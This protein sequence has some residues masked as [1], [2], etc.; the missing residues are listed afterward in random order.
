MR[1]TAGICVLLP[2]HS[3]ERRGAEVLVYLRLLEMFSF[4]RNEILYNIRMCLCGSLG[5][6]CSLLRFSW[7]FSELKT[8]LKIHF[9]LQYNIIED[10]SLQCL[11][12]LKTLPGLCKIHKNCLFF[13][14]LEWIWIE[15]ASTHRKWK[16][17]W[18]WIW[19]DRKRNLLIC[20]SRKPLLNPCLSNI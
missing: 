5:F 3:F 4:A 8:Q 19:I 14:S 15:L 1:H 9:I 7:D 2:C 11:A 6:G 18:N 17:N 13:K 16:W 10:S 12:T 20:C